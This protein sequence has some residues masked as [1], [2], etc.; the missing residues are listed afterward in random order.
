LVR[1]R[2]SASKSGIKAPEKPEFAD[3]WCGSSPNGL[4]APPQVSGWFGQADQIGLAGQAGQDAAQLGGVDMPGDVAAPQ[5]HVEIGMFAAEEFGDAQPAEPTPA[6]R[7]QEQS[8][9]GGIQADHDERRDAGRL[10]DMVLSGLEEIVV[11]VGGG[12]AALERPPIG[13]GGRHVLENR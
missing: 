7:P 1:A 3:R 4:V 10:A 5:R 2:S 11:L 12:E 9:A 8:L 6:E 13:L